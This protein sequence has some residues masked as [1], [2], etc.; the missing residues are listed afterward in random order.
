MKTHPSHNKAQ[1]FAC[2][3]IGHHLVPQPNAKAD[4]GQLTFPQKSR[5]KANRKLA[6]EIPLLLASSKEQ[7]K[8]ASKK[9]KVIVPKIQVDH[10]NPGGRGRASSEQESDSPT[11]YKDH[12]QHNSARSGSCYTN[13]GK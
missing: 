13:Y 4:Y 3:G 11:K 5:K 6:E 8:G 12:S 1:A 2:G 9:P 7:M 10:M